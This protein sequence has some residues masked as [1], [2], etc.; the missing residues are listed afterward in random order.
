MTE[1][2][3]STP[4]AATSPR[5]EEKKDDKKKEPPKKS[6]A[7]KTAELFVKLRKLY[8]DYNIPP[9]SLITQ[10]KLGEATPSQSVPVPLPA[11][12][13]LPLCKDVHS[14]ELLTS[15]ATVNTSHSAV[16]R[17]FCPSS[18]LSLFLRP[19]EAP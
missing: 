9:G 10:Q 3:G 12:C 16:G 17:S 18:S 1:P 13:T 4:A 8:T 15:P 7:Q 2:S 6:T 19:A 11:S 5:R 14:L